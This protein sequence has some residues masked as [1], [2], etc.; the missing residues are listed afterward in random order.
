MASMDDEALLE[1][2]RAGD[3]A[4]GEQLLTRHFETIRRFFVNKVHDDPEGLIQDTLLECVRKRDSYEGR[5]PFK[6]FLLGIARNLLRQHWRRQNVRGPT[7]AIDESSIAALGAGPSTIIGQNQDEKRLLDALRGISLGDQE[8]LELHYWE[9]L[10]GRELGEVVGLSEN[11]A[12]SRLHRAR[13]ALGDEYRRLERFA[14]V[15][16]S[17][18][19]SIDGWAMGVRDRLRNSGDR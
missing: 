3:E 5:S 18:D 9:R 7:A 1:A 14:G 12:R 16:E 8:I 11:G 10:T 17:S 19:G 6:Y 15:P 2:W 4:A 13:I